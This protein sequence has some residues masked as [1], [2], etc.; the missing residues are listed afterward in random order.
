LDLGKKG[1]IL[2]IEV[3]GPTPIDTTKFSHPIKII[4]EKQGHHP[5]AQIKHM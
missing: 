1:D 3:L 2:G 4:I 5:K